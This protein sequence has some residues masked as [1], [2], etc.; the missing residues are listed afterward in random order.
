[1]KSVLTREGSNWFPRQLSST[2]Q[3]QVLKRPIA[4]GCRLHCRVSLACSCRKLWRLSLDFPTVWASLQ[5]ARFSTPRQTLQFEAWLHS[6]RPHICKLSISTSTG[7]DQLGDE[8]LFLVGLLAGCERLESLTWFPT[9][10]ANIQ[11]GCWLR[12]LPRLQHLA[13]PKCLLKSHLS[14]VTTL[15][16]LYIFGWRPTTV[17]PG[18]FPASLQTLTMEGAPPTLVATLA[19]SPVAA[20]LR[21]LEVKGCRPALECNELGSLVALT[22]LVLRDCSLAEVPAGVTAL[23]ALQRLGLRMNL[24]GGGWDHLLH[25][26]AL[27]SLDLSWQGPNAL[28]LPPE[29]LTAPQLQV[30]NKAA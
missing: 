23:T 26:A 22:S 18:C 20:C 5:H 4:T 7:V 24:L 15:R 19:G 10:E 30:G 13:A 3:A 6:R 27:S 17:E 1:M 25:L 14:C 21:S 9:S 28:L 12:F 11:L 2:P 8:A 16:S 29:L